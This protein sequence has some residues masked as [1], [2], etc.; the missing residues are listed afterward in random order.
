MFSTGSICEYSDSDSDPLP[1][2]SRSLLYLEFLH[3]DSI[4]SPLMAVESPHLS[5]SCITRRLL[6]ASERTNW[7][8]LAWTPP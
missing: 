4:Q 5:L 7:D 1:S 8:I 6:F 3:L 2:V